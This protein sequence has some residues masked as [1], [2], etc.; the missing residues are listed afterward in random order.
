MLFWLLFDRCCAA[1][2]CLYVSRKEFFVVRQNATYQSGYFY[3]PLQSSVILRREKPEYT[4]RFIIVICIVVNCL[5][6]P[7]FIPS[8]T[9][10][11]STMLV[12]F[13]IFNKGGL[14]LF[15]HSD[16]DSQD[17]TT[18]SIS[19]SINTWLSDTYL[20]PTKSLTDRKA[21]IDGHP[22]NIILEWEETPD[23]IAVATYPDI[24]RED[25]PW[26]RTLLRASLSEFQLFCQAQGA[27]DGKEPDLVDEYYP[28][29]RELFDKTFGVLFKQ[30]KNSQVVSSSNKEI[31]KQ[32]AKKKGGKEKRQWHDGKAKVTKEAMAELD[33]SKAKSTDDNGDDDNDAI[34]LA[35]ARAAYLPTDADLA[36][37]E[38]VDTSAL[39][40][41]DDS[42]NSWGGSLKGLFQQ[43]TGQK[44]LSKQD[45][46]QP[47]QEIHKLL[48]S[49]NV[50]S[51]I[52]EQICQNVEQSLVGKKLN[53]MYR[54]KTA[55]R[56]ALEKAINKLLLPSAKLDLLRQVVSKRD[57]L[58]GSKR[59]YVIVVVGINGVGKSTSVAKLAYYLK[60]NGCNPVRRERELYCRS[61]EEFL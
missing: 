18:A 41:D 33:R 55:V 20:N 9:T 45:L 8:E 56:Q 19:D 7:L 4:T 23:L 10:T 39:D 17:F 43:V 54:V 2:S 59:P 3:S 46:Q 31:T 12:S 37:F 21:V 52:A 47:I 44:F 27:E 28:E 51:D 32:Q 36:E 50:A 26:I 6:R 49:K 15:Q 14:V 11:H 5:H 57:S 1:G 58:F 61:L 48:T 40:D 16:E 34:A 22:T 24:R 53:S 42:E 38:I 29:N 13:T 60:S 25:F 30:H 35:E